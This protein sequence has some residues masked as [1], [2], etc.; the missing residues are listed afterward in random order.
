[1][2][3]K[4]R[5]SKGRRKSSA[6]SRGS[7]GSSMSQTPLT[8]WDELLEAVEEVS[9]ELGYSPIYR[10]RDVN[11]MKH[12]S[13]DPHQKYSLVYP[14]IQ[15]LREE[16]SPVFDYEFE[17]KEENL[18]ISTLRSPCQERRYS[19][20]IWEC[21]PCDD[22]KDMT[23]C[24]SLS[25]SY[26]TPLCDD[27]NFTENMISTSVSYVGMVE[28]SNQLLTID[29][30][31]GE[32]SVFYGLLVSFDDIIRSLH[33]KKFSTQSVGNFV[34]YVLKVIPHLNKTYPPSYVAHNLRN[35]IPGTPLKI[36][37]TNELVQVLSQFV[38]GL[39]GLKGRELLSELRYF[40]KVLFT[41]YINLIELVGIDVSGFD[42]TILTNQ[43]EQKRVLDV[44]IEMITTRQKSFSM[45]KKVVKYIMS[46]VDKHPNV[47]PNPTFDIGSVADHFEEL[48]ECLL[49]R[50]E[51]VRSCIRSC[52]D[53]GHLN[54]MLYMTTSLSV[55]LDLII[56]FIK[57][58][59]FDEYGTILGNIESHLFVYEQ[60]LPFH[61]GATKSFDIN[62]A[63]QWMFNTSPNLI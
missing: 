36:N 43:M 5:G 46:I 63:I 62:K 2:P 39:E 61:T 55:L 56:K 1:M 41:I 18:P 12:L 9:S 40:I 4:K 3:R 25:S 58:E 45:K 49:L 48:V 20:G 16:T 14:A 24:S 52:L 33:A 23:F 27:A 31:Y 7:R 53:W 8:A 54:Y 28:F 44:T 32:N 47:P 15:Y 60:L 34:K 11:I 10:N 6:S 30:Y 13:R 42:E 35:Y 59:F 38:G 57:P 29:K 50:V 21:V 26:H 51:H 37:E 19:D 17:S 22:D